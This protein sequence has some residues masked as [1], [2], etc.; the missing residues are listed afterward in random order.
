MHPQVPPNRTLHDIFIASVAL[1]V[2]HYNKYRGLLRIILFLSG[3]F[4]F[5][6]LSIGLHKNWKTSIENQNKIS[7]STKTNLCF[8]VINFRG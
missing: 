8:A 5:N 2:P 1:T 7:F 4:T 6:N 3:Q